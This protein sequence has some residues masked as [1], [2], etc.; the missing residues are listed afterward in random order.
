MAKTNPR[1][2]KKRSEPQFFQAGGSIGLIIAAIIIVAGIAVIYKWMVI[3]ALENDRA[4]APSGLADN[5]KGGDS[6]S[7]DQ[8]QKLIKSTG[9]NLDSTTINA[10]GIPINNDAW[11]QVTT[12]YPEFYAS[13]DVPKYQIDLTKKWYEI[14]SKA[15]GNYGPT[16][17]WIVGNS[18]SEAI[19]LTDQYCELRIKKGQNISKTDC[20]N[21]HSFVDYSKYGGAGLS[22]FRNNWDNWSGFVIGISSKPPPEVDDYKVIILHE[23]FHV[24]QHA[25]IFSKDD[26]ERDSRNKKNPWWAEG[27]AEYMAQ[28]LYS[29]QKGVNSSYL[30]SAMKS[31][32]NSLSQLGSNENIKNI[33]YDDEKTHIAYDIGAWFIA[34]L[35]HKTNEETYRVKFFKNLNS[36]F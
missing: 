36:F 34:F 14:A 11:G 6:T 27:G 12:Q 26:F 25:H 7:G 10:S 23:Y 31:K 21:G 16:E 18:Q 3:P 32:L 28:L 4:K 13:K 2:V 33:P 17:F 29:K 22:T 8:Q 19:E 15:W 24:Y 1:S 35:I 9:A 5:G 30:K 20:I